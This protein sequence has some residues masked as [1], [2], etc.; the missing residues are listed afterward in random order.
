MDLT[1][2]S[3]N[4]DVLTATTTLT[5]SY[6]FGPRAKDL[7]PLTLEIEG[8]RRNYISGDLGT[9]LAS[10]AGGNVFAITP[11]QQKSAWIGEVRLLSGGMDFT[12][13]LAA[14]AER[15]AGNLDYSGR[16]SLSLAF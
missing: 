2:L 15:I 6:R 16:A 12:W 14:R 10:F 9:T 7:R 3:R 8:G 13:K 5:G 4:S 11:D 1:V